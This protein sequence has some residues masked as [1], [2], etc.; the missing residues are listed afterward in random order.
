MWISLWFTK[1]Y[2]SAKFTKKKQV[3]NKS[4]SFYLADRPNKIFVKT[5]PTK[6]KIYLHA[7]RK[8]KMTK[9]KIG[10]F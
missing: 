8:V 9:N 6:C 10:I 2:K 7:I 4:D 3:V 5:C 1:Y